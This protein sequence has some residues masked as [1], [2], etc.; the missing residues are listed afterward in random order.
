[1]V[2][3]VAAVPPTVLGLTVYLAVDMRRPDQEIWE[4]E[5]VGSAA[6]RSDRMRGESDATSD[7]EATYVNS[8]DD[9]VAAEAGRPGPNGA[10]CMAGSTAP[11]ETRRRLGSHLPLEHVLE[12]RRMGQAGDLVLI[13]PAA[14]AAAIHRFGQPTAGD[15]VHS[16]RNDHQ[17]LVRAPSC[18]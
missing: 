5:L 18:G 16:L 3:A 10:S 14:T 13:V 2:V 6:S 9:R 12:R 11:K 4:G 1:M 8:C 15:S 17:V 7:L